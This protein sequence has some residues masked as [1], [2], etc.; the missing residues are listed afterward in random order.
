MPQK[1]TLPGNAAN[2][3]HET[4]C[5]FLKH[6]IFGPLIFIEFILRQIKEQYTVKLNVII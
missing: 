6:L 3:F 5:L 4:S 1:K 2:K